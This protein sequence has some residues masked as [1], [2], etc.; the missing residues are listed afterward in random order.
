MKV[1]LI[2]PPS[3][4]L[5]NDAACPPS[6]LMYLAAV[7]ENTGHEVEIL[8]LTGGL[9]W[10]SI[11][12]NLEADVFGIT[13]VTPDFNIVQELSRLLPK[14]TPVLVGG[15]HPTHLPEDTLKN[16]RCDSVL[17]GEGEIIIKKMIGDLEK[18]RLQRIYNGG[19]VPI[20]AIPKPARHL[21]DLH[22]YHPGGD[23]TTPIYTSRGCPFNCN[24]CSRITERTF[25]AFP[26]P[27]VLEEIKEVM[28]LGFKHVYFGD[29]NIVIQRERLNELL[30]AVKPL[31]IEFRLNQDARTVDEETIALAADAGCT[32]ISFGIES[33]SQRMLDL[34]NKRTT[35]EANKKAMLLTK[36][37]G[38]KAK[39]Y[40]VVNFPGE[41]EETVRE[42][43]RFISEVRPDKWLLSAFAPLP[44]SDTFNHP[45]KYG[46]T[47]MSRNWEDYYL[48]GRDGKFK[49]CFTT[50]ELSF[51]RQ[52]YFQ[53]LLIESL[54]EQIGKQH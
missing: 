54:R 41:T 1:V 17:R 9:D 43:I 4:Y 8:D 31:G 38:I 51:E 5:D 42:T 6:G 35:I 49:P 46:I 47:W 11:V 37:H 50:K 28:S 26:I 27:R 36:K 30:R 32:E 19:I 20:D 52:I 48:V 39:A 40:I 16:V 22:R 12:P 14:G 34:M 21:V 25:R 23:A 10:R 15:V 29:D 2:N 24:F 18:G 13:C 44:G 45:E 53:N 7:L 3:P 33:G